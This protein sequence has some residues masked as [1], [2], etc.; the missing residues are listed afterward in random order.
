MKEKLKSIIYMIL[1]VWTISAFSS[2]ITNMIT[3]VMMN[4]YVEVPAYI[5]DVTSTHSHRHHYRVK[6]H[7][8]LHYSYNGQEYE[9]KRTSI[10]APDMELDRAWLDPVNMTKVET[11]SKE[12][13]SKRGY[14]L[15]AT[16]VVL[17]FITVLMTISRKKKS[18]SD[19]D[20]HGYQDYRDY[21]DHQSYN[22][23][24]GQSANRSIRI[25]RYKNFPLG[26]VFAGVFAG[27][28]VIAGAITSLLGVAFTKSPEQARIEINGRLLQGQ[29]S[30]E[31]AIR[32]GKVLLRVGSIAFVVAFILMVITCLLLFNR[33]SK[34]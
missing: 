11:D 10:N 29:E 15:L 8:T 26:A 19:E 12:K 23:Y 18:E 7:Y 4:R 27:W 1:I 2:G 30:V 25:R 28:S 14:M 6:Y 21:Q 24:S 17:G 31:T 32:W 3:S 34:N 16:S 33:Y 20:Y 22:M 5:T 13:H 9:D